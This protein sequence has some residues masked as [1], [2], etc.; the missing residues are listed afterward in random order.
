MPDVTQTTEM[1]ADEI[2]AF[3][4]EN[5]TG[6]LSLA[7]GDNAYAVPETFGYDGERIYFKF[8]Y[9]DE[10]K[11][12]Q[13]L[14][15]TAR[16]AFVV[17][18]TDNGSFRSVVA[19]GPIRKVPDDRV[20]HALSVLESHAGDPE[21]SAFALPDEEFDFAVYALDVETINGRSRGA[22]DDT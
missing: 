19:T 5:G 22:G 8:G 6:V 10:S 15:T 16:A 2:T 21:V 18:D 14:G 11:K 7:H 9:H 13:Y 20:D 17:Y 3:L 12:V 4:K 1:G